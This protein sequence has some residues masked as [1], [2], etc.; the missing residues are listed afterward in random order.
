MHSPV[1]FQLRNFG[2]NST[3]LCIHVCTL[4]RTPS[5]VYTKPCAHNEAIKLSKSMSAPR[6]SLG[7]WW[8]SLTHLGVQPS[9]TY[10]HTH[11]HTQTLFACC[12]SHGPA[13]GENSEKFPCDQRV[14]APSSG[15]HAAHHEATFTCAQTANITFVCA[16]R[17]RAPNKR[18][19]ALSHT[20]TQQQLRR[21]AAACE[22]MPT[23]S[24][25]CAP[26]IGDHTQAGARTQT[27][28]HIYW[29][30][31]RQQCSVRRETINPIGNNTLEYIS[32]VNN[33]LVLKL[34]SIHP[35]SIQSFTCKYEKQNTYL[36]GESSG[37]MTHAGS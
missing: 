31:T 19:R 3:P 34:S 26:R 24:E 9:R 13:T 7:A 21:V 12:S 4:C 8:C 32:D 25:K 17:A 10:T 37:I 6:S 1:T 29:A 20:H 22:S 18:G 2:T 28:A 33:V 16:T 15:A 27:G 14:H 35:V 36:R 11:T 5:H 30:Q 23:T